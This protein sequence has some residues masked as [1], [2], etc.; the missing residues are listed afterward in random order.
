M[1]P[2]QVITG[3]L[4]SMKPP[5]VI[6]GTLRSMEPPQVITGTLQSMKPLN[7]SG[8]MIKTYKKLIKTCH[9]LLCLCLCLHED[10]L[11]LARKHLL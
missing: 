4:W 8:I 6:T 5:Q 11:P 1:K 9:G 7:N 2:P 3:I 10:E